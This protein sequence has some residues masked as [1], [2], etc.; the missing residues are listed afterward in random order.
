MIIDDS[1]L[2]GLQAELADLDESSEKLGFV[3]WQWEYYRATYDLKIEDQPN[4]EDY[5]LRINTRAVEGKLENPSAVLAVEDVYIGRASFPH[6]LD[7]ES[8]IPDAILKSAKQKL[9]ALKQLLA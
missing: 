6:G 9:A 2:K 3:R 4:R 8:P 1:G 7:Y 5:F